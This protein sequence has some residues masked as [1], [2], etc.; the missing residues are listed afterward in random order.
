MS[1]KKATPQKSPKGRKLQIKDLASAKDPKGGT[2]LT[3]VL[4]TKK[5]PG[6]PDDPKLQWSWGMHKAG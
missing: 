1:C 6:A 5:P 3:D 4:D 2:T